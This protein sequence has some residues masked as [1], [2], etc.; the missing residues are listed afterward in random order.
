MSF[1]NFSELPDTARVWIFGAAEPLGSTQVQS[2]NENMGLFLKQW[3]AHKKEL[4]PS[5]E[6]R[7]NQFIVIGLD[8][9]MMAASGCSIDSMVHN[10]K[11]FEVTVGA[12]ISGT[13]L[14]VFYRD[15][16]DTI[17]CVGRAEFKHLVE[18]GSVN[19]ETVVF[20]NTIETVADLK[21]NRWEVPMKES[22]HMQAFGVLV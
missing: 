18:S 19:E 2:L 16:H 11:N 4:N 1:V 20:N 22:W 6:L 21:Q 8:E 7:H 13:S 14:K 5:W 15:E 17:Q 10:L 9:R 12:N 3:T